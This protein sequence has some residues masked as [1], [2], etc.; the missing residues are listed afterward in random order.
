MVTHAER[1][2]AGWGRGRRECGEDKWDTVEHWLCLPPPPHSSS[3]SFPIW[4]KD[5]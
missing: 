5:H 3:F 4:N 1:R 2:K